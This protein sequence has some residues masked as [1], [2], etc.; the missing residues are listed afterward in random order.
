MLATEAKLLVELQA[1]AQRA[2]AELLHAAQHE[3]DATRARLRALTALRGAAER[4]RAD[5]ARL[6][7]ASR[8]TA[9]DAAGKQLADELAAASATLKVALRTPGPADRA[10]D[11]HRAAAAAD[12]YV[13]AWRAGT[14]AALSKWAQATERPPLTTA[15]TTSTALQDHRLR[16]IAATEVPQAYSEEHA[17]RADQI[18]VQHADAKWLVL[19]VKCWDAT[20]DRKLCAVCRDMNR[21]WAVVGTKFKGGLLPGSVHAHCRCQDSLLVMKP[22]VMI[23][24]SAYL[25]ASAGQ[26]AA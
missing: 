23:P 13:A 6:T 20:L 9:R 1:A 5:V 22:G 26:R 12:S 4:L 11:E 18:A 21:R 16:R 8:G 17:A 24:G 19:L 10:D 2:L 3:L 25:G 15:L 14:A 7:Q